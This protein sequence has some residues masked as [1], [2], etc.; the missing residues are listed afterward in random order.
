MH[1]DSPGPTRGT[2]E[3]HL[4]AQCSRITR[5]L[6]GA[7]SADLVWVPLW[8]PSKALVVSRHIRVRGEGFPRQD[9]LCWGVGTPRGGHPS[10]PKA[11]VPITSVPMFGA[12]PLSPVWGVHLWVKA[13][14]GSAGVLETVNML[15]S[16]AC[17]VLTGHPRE[18]HISKCCVV[19][20]I[21]AIPCCHVLP[22]GS[23]RLS[24]VTQRRGCCHSTSQPWCYEGSD[25]DSVPVP[26]HEAV[27]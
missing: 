24:D 20:L 27:T 14:S 26:I 11:L 2:Q 6:E 12:A 3:K 16:K 25:G 19:P 8:R 1:C 15:L 21:L 9:R 23:A 10:I 17:P 4:T 13:C 18:R 7:T 22:M 5:G